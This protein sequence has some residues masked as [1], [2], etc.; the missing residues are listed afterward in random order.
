MYYQSYCMTS[1]P[2]DVWYF[3][4]NNSCSATC[5]Y[6]KYIEGTILRCYIDNCGGMMVQLNGYC[7]DKCPS[8]YYVDENQNCIPCN[9]DQICDKPFTVDLAVLRS[10]NLKLA[11]Y[12]SQKPV[13]V[14][15]SKITITFKDVDGNNFTYEYSSLQVEE[16]RIIIQYGYVAL[17]LSTVDVELPYVVS[18]DTSQSIIDNTLTANI[19][20]YNNYQDYSNNG[21]VKEIA[22]VFVVLMLIITIMNIAAKA[23]HYVQLM[24][25]SQFIAATLYL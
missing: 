4:Q 25:F 19:Y 15:S 24:D 17:T 7:L 23:S 22:V 8:Q 10:H 1:C 11:I 20:Y 13:S 16:Y 18:A 12:F 6:Y 3:P 21:G 5:T 9:D 2:D 14:D